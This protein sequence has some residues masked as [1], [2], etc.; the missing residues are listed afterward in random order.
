MRHCGGSESLNKE[1]RRIGGS[2][3][4]RDRCAL[5]ITGRGGL[6]LLEFFHNLCGSTYFEMGGVEGIQ[7]SNSHIYRGAFGWSGVL[8][9]ARP[10]NLQEM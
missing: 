4:G 10:Q 3:N 2:R 6:I 5:A 8:V 1:V 9:K 7:F